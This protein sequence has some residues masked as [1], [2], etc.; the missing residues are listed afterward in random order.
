MTKDAENLVPTCP[1][2]QIHSNEHH[3]ATNLY[4]IFKTPIPFAQWGIDFLGSFQKA[5]AGKNHF[6]VAIDHFT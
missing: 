5:L 1:K 4:H 3:L 6:V 2:C